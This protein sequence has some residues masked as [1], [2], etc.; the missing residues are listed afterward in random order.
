MRQ[1]LICLCFAM[2]T[3]CGQASDDPGA[4]G[5]TAGE[6][7]TLRDAAQRLDSRSAAPGADDSRALETEVKDR[8][9]QE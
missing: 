3:G 4:G 8:V 5:L 1:M 6:T 2:C 7:E 9:A